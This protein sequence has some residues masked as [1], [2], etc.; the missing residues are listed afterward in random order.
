MEN[1]AVGTVTGTGA[2]INISLGWI[3]DY[4]KVH[5]MDG[6]VFHEWYRGMDDG[7][8]V[9]TTTA[10]ALL[11]SNGISDYVGDSSNKPGFSIGTD[12]SENLKVLR[13]VAMRNT[14]R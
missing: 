8:A 7:T 1:L 13:Y 5:N 6:D 9:K 14:D 2:A 12:V 10:V 3:P 4:V 11:G